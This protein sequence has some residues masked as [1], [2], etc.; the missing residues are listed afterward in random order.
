MSRPMKAWKNLFAMLAVACVIAWIVQMR[1]QPSRHQRALALLDT[2]ESVSN[3]S[4][5]R[6][7][8]VV[9]D[10]RGEIQEVRL[11][12]DGTDMPFGN[13]ELRTLSAL[14]SLEK[15]VIF[16]SQISDGGLSVIRA[17]PRL[18]T[19]AINNAPITDAALRHLEH[20]HS[21]RQAQFKGTSV[22]HAAATQ[23]HATIPGCQI[24]DSWCCGCMTIE[25]ANNSQPKR[26]HGTVVT[27]PAG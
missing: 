20:L 22:S 5:R 27:L 16:D 9:R 15:L 25:A 14:P 24:L 13:D 19:I 1:R 17:M 3:S 26:L 23:L 11:Y 21:L 12:L 6:A 7:L 8:R 2:I 18:Q 4:Q 10:D